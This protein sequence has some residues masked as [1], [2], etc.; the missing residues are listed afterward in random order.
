MFH[1]EDEFQAHLDQHPDDHTARQVFADW[2]D[3]Q[4]DPR[5][6]GYRAL[7]LLG[8]RP[9]QIEQLRFHPDDPT[10]VRSERVPGFAYH[11]GRGTA[12]IDH[13]H[14]QVGPEHALPQDW[15]DRISGADNRYWGG[16]ERGDDG[17]YYL[18]TRREAEDEAA[19]A[20]AELSPERQAELLERPA[21]Y[22]RR[23]QAVRH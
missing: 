10:G 9:F 21:V 19:T 16:R 18:T 4:R 6:A 2:L 15:L 11:N 14:R 12:T 5:A 8:K 3:E 7:G 17:T 20:F 23:R 13:V 22:R 1:T